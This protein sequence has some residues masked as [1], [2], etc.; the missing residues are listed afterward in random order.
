MIVGS[1]VGAGSEGGPRWYDAEGKAY[2]LEAIR[3]LPGRK[4]AIGTCSK[5][6]APYVDR[7][8]VGCM[9][10]PNAP[11][12]I[13]HELGGKPCKVMS[14]RN[15]NLIPMLLALLGQRAARRRLLQEGQRLDV[16]LRLEE[17]R[18][19]ARAL[20]PEESARDWVEWPLPPLGAE[21]TQKLLGFEDDAALAGLRGML[22]F[23]V[24]EK[25]L[26]IL[27]ALVTGAITV[28]P[29]VCAV[30]S[31]AR[32]PVAGIAWYGW[33]GAFA[34]IEALHA[35]EIPAALRASRRSRERRGLPWTEADRRKAVVG[36]LLVGYPSWVPRNLG[37]FE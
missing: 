5:I 20:S 15:R 1:G 18:V 24:K 37:V 9:P 35:L 2:D 7:Y 26:W 31:L 29:A 36:A 23:R 8:I 30:V 3:A 34:A 25:L 16:P 4:M 32:R 10:M 22:V 19:E 13:L 6:L 28:S 17:G 21:E 33:L 11:H 12:M 27:K 14:L